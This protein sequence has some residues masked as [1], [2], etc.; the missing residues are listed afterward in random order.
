MWGCLTWIWIFTGNFREISPLAAV[1]Q[2][3]GT[4]TW[5]QLWGGSQIKYFQKWVH[6][7]ILSYSSESIILK[8]R[9]RLCSPHSNRQWVYTERRGIHGGWE[10]WDSF[11]AHPFAAGL[12]SHCSLFPKTHPIKRGWW[13]LPA[14]LLVSINWDKEGTFACQ[15]SC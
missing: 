7:F 3:S 6:L 12:Q 15:C 9:P 11:Q 10:T 13:Y 2:T 14:W 8:V 1:L 5:L 4:I